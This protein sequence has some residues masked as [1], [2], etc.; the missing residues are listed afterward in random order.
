M[1]K[2]SNNAERHKYQEYYNDMYTSRR[3]S[4]AEAE[5]SWGH[6]AKDAEQEQCLTWLHGCT[7]SIL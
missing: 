4:R 3:A 7:Y 5:G 6:S 1:V 2:Y